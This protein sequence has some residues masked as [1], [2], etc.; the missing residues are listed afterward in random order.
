MAHCRLALFFLSR[1][2]REAIPGG[3]QQG[4]EQPAIS[5]FAT[6]GLCGQGAGRHIAIAISREVN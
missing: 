2:L 4:A 3:G 1:P 6:R 5:K